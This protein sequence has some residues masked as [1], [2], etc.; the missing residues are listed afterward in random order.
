MTNIINI[1]FKSKQQLTE[2][3]LNLTNNTFM[4]INKHNDIIKHK[5]KKNYFF[6]ETHGYIFKNNMKFLVSIIFKDGHKETQEMCF[7]DIDNYMN[8]FVF[9]I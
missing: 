5:L 2:A 1:N 3:E 9:N 4:F 6:K 8:E 7:R